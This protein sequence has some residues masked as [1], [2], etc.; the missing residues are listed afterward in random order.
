MSCRFV[1]LVS[2]GIDCI[3]PVFPFASYDVVWCRESVV[4]CRF[5]FIRSV[6]RRVVG[7]VRVVYCISPM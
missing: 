3:V 4:P 6:T 2:S 7:V 5:L 1:G